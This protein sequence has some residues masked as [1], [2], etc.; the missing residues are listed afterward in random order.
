MPEQDSLAALQSTAQAA[1]QAKANAA[2]NCYLSTIETAAQALA[3]TCPQIGKPYEQR[4]SRLRARLAFDSGMEKIEESRVAAARELH[5][6][7]EQAS[8]YAKQQRAE[9]RR[10][11][12]GLEEIVKTQAQRQ[13]FYGERVRRLA[14]QLEQQP[15]TAETARFSEG[16][17][18]CV[19]SMSHESQS[20]LKKMCDEMASLETRLAGIEITDRVTG[21]INRREMERLI[22]AVM[23]RGET[24]VLLLFDFRDNLQ[25]DVARQVSA[26][27]G[28]QFRHHDL[29][30]RWSER[31]FLVLFQGSPEMAQRR[32]EQ[33]LPWIAGRYQLEGGAVV[34]AAVEARLIDE[35]RLAEAE[36]AAY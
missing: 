10:A 7:A 11:I 34:E 1:A 19:E 2:V 28:A 20:V 24:P 33:I 25:D 26:R 30:S 8:E 14:M 3:E 18:N 4:L 9:L 16:L 22:A 15:Q 6:Y 5:N 32:G 13:E 29:I 21:L 27:L 31:Q 36:L 12:A 23:A 35:A 17:K